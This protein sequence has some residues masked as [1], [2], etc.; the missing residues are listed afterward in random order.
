VTPRTH[1]RLEFIF[2][3]RLPLLVEVRSAASNNCDINQLATICYFLKILLE[4]IAQ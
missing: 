2:C 4:Q 1:R 3:D